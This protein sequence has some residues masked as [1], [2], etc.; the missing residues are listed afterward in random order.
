MRGPTSVEAL[1]RPASELEPQKAGFS[2]A[3][4]FAP[5]NSDRAWESAEMVRRYAHLTAEHL[6]PYADRL[7]SLGLV[8]DE[9]DG[10]NTAHA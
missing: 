5:P 1:G 7:C 10:T 8:R 4:A 6:A 2:E 3:A 9:S